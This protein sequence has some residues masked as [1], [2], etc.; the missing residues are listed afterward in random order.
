MSCEVTR[1]TML[2]VGTVHDGFWGVWGAQGGS[3][4]VWG[5]SRR[6]LLYPCMAL[7]ALLEVLYGT[8]FDSKHHILVQLAWLYS[9]CNTDLL[10]DLWGPLGAP[11]RPL[12]DVLGTFR[13]VKGGLL[14][15]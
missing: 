11:K 9:V 6:G 14:D 12:Y 7:F 15:L 4:G 13:G 10:L 3:G 5:G 8:R 2:V 1:G